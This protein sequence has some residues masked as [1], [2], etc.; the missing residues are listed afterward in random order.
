LS[1][2]LERALLQAR[3]MGFFRT[4][5]AGVLLA[6]CS[7]SVESNEPAD[8]QGHIALTRADGSKTVALTRG[9]HVDLTLQTVG[10]GSYGE[11]QLSSSAV[12]F[13]GSEYAKE[14]VPAGP[15]Q[16][17]HFVGVSQGEADITILRGDDAT[18]RPFTIKLRVE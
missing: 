4:L 6:G 7:G 8:T 15:T 10:P 14:P 2:A 16:L 5:T 1:L 11:P 17:Y 12:R 9:Q 18:D 3:G 13:D